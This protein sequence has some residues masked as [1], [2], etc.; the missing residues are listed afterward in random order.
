VL[1]VCKLAA[2]NSDNLFVE[3]HNLALAPMVRS[4]KR[5]EAPNF[6]FWAFDLSAVGYSLLKVAGHFL[7]RL[8][9]MHTNFLVLLGNLRPSVSCDLTVD[10]PCQCQ[11]AMLVTASALSDTSFPDPATDYCDRWCRHRSIQLRSQ[12]LSDLAYPAA[13]PPDLHS[14]R[15]PRLLLYINRVCLQC[16]LPCALSSI[17]LVLGSSPDQK[18]GHTPTNIYPESA[19]A[20]KCPFFLYIVL[21]C[22]ID[23]NED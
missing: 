13:L 12:D 8:K 2:L 11:G 19:S 6:N 22:L 10:Y 17:L 14:A 23:F 9:M 1:K 4:S 20:F 5:K 16:H 21:F 3:P 18:P 15:A 7:H